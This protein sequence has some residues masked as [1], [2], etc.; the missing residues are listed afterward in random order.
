MPGYQGEATNWNTLARSRIR[1]ETD[2]SIAE[3]MVGASTPQS[4]AAHFWHARNEQRHSPRLLSLSPR[5]VFL[6]MPINRSQAARSRVTVANSEA[7]M[8]TSVRRS[9]TLPVTTL[10]SNALCLTLRT[11]TA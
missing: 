10:S 7:T 4:S 5:L 2:D 8:P 6:Q 9:L 1:A 3:F 11:W